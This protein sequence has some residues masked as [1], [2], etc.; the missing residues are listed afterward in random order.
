M[1][2]HG[3]GAVTPGSPDAARPG[4]WWGK[5][6]R[7]RARGERGHSSTGTT[8][9]RG[10]RTAGSGA[11]RQGGGPEGCSEWQPREGR[12]AGQGAKG[13]PRTVRRGPGPSVDAHLGVRSAAGSRRSSTPGTQFVSSVQSA[14]SPQLQP[15]EKREK[16]QV[17]RRL[18]R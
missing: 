4:G 12:S 13:G 16:S 14:C 11:Q 7:C 5:V 15:V 1:T 18:G 8:A 2:V 9:G 3:Q 6:K 17:S 10:R